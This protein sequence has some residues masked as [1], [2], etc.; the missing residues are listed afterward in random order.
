MMLTKFGHTQNLNQD[1]SKTG[2]NRK[3]DAEF[4]IQDKIL[5]IHATDIDRTSCFFRFENQ[6]E[7]MTKDQKTSTK[8][9]KP[10]VHCTYE[11]RK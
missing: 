3:Y 1:Q 2:L 8:Q 10:I 7:K 6:R 5:K 9:I 4:W 11:G